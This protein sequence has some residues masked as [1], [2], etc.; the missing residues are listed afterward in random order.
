MFFKLH[1]S[2]HLH[3]LEG[4]GKLLQ[5]RDC[6]V[7]RLAFAQ[8][9]FPLAKRLLVIELHQK[10]HGS[11]LVQQQDLHCLLLR[12]FVASIASSFIFSVEIK[13]ATGRPVL[14]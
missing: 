9:R 12:W 10:A 3:S 2:L 4:V 5:A 11:S 14:A 6:H 13:A 1:K 8:Q 7:A